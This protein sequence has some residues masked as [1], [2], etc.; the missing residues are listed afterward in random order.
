RGEGH[1]RHMIEMQP[2]AHYIILEEDWAHASLTELV[3]YHQTMGGQ[4]FM[5]ILTVPCGQ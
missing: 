3:Q 1:C 4:P 5:E 2:N